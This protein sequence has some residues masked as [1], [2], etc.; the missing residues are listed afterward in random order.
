MWKSIV[1]QPFVEKKIQS[2][3]FSQGSIGIGKSFKG[4]INESNLLILPFDSALFILNGYQK[5]RTNFKVNRNLL[6]FVTI[7]K[8]W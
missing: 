8:K 2:N 7:M 1:R 5:L 4:G 6:T 3:F